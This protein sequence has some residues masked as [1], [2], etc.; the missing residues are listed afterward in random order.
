MAVDSINAQQPIDHL[1]PQNPEAEEAVLGSLLMDPEATGKVAAFLKAEDFYRE[2]NGTIYTVVLELYDQHEPVDFLTIS[3]E[4]RRRGQYDEVG[5]LAYLSRLVS[6]VPTAIHVEHYGHI[7]ERTAIKRRLISAAGKIAAIAYD[8]SVDVDTTLEKAEQ[9]LYGVSQRRVTKDFEQL[10]VIL[11]D[12]LEQMQLQSDD[13]EGGGR[14]IPTNFIELD[15]L[16]G[17]L[18]RSD[19]IILAARPSMGKSTLALNIVQNAALR[20][21]VTCAVFSLEMSKQQL[22]HRLLCSESGVDATKLRLGMIGDVEQRK[23]HRA[24][25]L[26]SEAP[27][28]ID[29]TASI[30]LSELRSKARRLQSEVG[31]DMVIV[32]YLQLI[33]TGRG[34]DNRVQEISEISR[35][36]KALARELN[37]PVIAL[38]QL[39]RA[40][41]ARTPHIPMLS[42]LRESGSIEQDA[43]IVLFIYREDMYNKDTDKKGIADIYLAK[44]RNGPT[45]QFPLLFL[46][47]S[48]RFVNLDYRPGDQ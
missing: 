37:A 30:N 6:A 43:D 45:G 23:L 13:K 40:V 22:A 9:L 27:I 33:T 10:G 41:E 47:S 28:Y 12:Y 14:G 21:H 26:L 39:S 48:T 34:G 36:L 31:I 42:D 1:P 19:L 7:V 2:R 44:H 17:G 24:F 5:G 18:Q 8:D 11:G 3:D 29:D 25:E 16:T 32:D 38:S 20:N 35:Q 4:L 46:D 15:K